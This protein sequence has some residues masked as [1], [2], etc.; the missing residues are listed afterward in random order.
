MLE[1]LQTSTIPILN[2]AFR[3]SIKHWRKCSHTAHSHTNIQH[4]MQC[5]PS[6]FSGPEEIKSPTGPKRK[7]KEEEA[8]NWKKQV[9]MK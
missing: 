9:N 7:K 8:W 1:H 2:L 5:A 4:S 6:S 3:V